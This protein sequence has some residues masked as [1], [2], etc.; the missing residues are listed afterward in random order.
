M[1]NIFDSSQVKLLQLSS[2]RIKQCQIGSIWRKSDVMNR[3]FHDRLFFNFNQEI[4]VLALFEFVKIM[5]INEST[6]ELCYERWNMIK[7]KT[8]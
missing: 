3:F 6:T 2:H 5:Q 8:F 1:V 4:S 7:K